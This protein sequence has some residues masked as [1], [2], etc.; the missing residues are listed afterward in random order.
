MMDNKD[1]LS[2]GCDIWVDVQ[3]SQGNFATRN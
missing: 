2:G 3:I 1:Y